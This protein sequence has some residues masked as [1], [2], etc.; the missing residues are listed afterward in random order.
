[1]NVSELYKLDYRNLPADEK[2]AW[3]YD[4]YRR[5]RA[6]IDKYF[7]SYGLD[8][9]L[10]VGMME[11]AKENDIRYDTMIRVIDAKLLPP[12][13]QELSEIESLFADLFDEVL[14]PLP[15]EFEDEQKNRRIVNIG[16]F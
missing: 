10:I 3:N 8:I 13:S 9:A 1:M 12:Y 4:H 11:R 7:V 5:T 14:R 6:A 2:S 15:P 16:H